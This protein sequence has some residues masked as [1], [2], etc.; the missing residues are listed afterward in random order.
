[1]ILKCDDLQ[2]GFIKY[3]GSARCFI[4]TRIN[5]LNVNVISSDS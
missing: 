2:F 5:Y 1:M 4:I 3:D